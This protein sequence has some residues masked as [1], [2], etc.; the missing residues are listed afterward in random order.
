MTSAAFHKTLRAT[1]YLQPDGSPAVGLIREVSEGPPRL[2]PAIDDQRIGLMA[3]AVFTVRGAVVS[4]FKDAGS[5]RP[6][7]EEEASWHEAAWNLGLAPLLWVVTPTEVRL[8]DCYSPAVD[9]DGRPE[10]KPIGV[11]GLDAETNLQ[12]LDRACGRLSTETGAFWS[13]PIGSRINRR[14]RVDRQ[15]LAEIKALEEELS[16]LEPAQPRHED[17]TEQ[18]PSQ[19]RDFAQRLIGRTIFTWF[20]LDRGELAQPILTR[21]GAKSLADMLT[22]RERAFALFDWLRE[23]FNGDLFPMDDPEAERDRLTEDHLEPLR[24]FADSVSLVPGARGQGRLFRFRFDA[25]PVDL[26]S[27]IYQ[28]FARSSAAQS[29]RDQSLHYTPF[30]LIHL[31]LD[32]VFEGLEADARVI[33]PTCGSGAFLVEAFRRLVWMKTKGRPASRSIVREVLYNQLFGMDINLAALRIAAFGLYLTALELDEDPVASPSDLRFEALIGRTLFE[34]DALDRIPD[35]VTS[36]TFGAVVGNPPWQYVSRHRKGPK[37]MQGG[38]DDHRPRRSPDQSFLLAAGRLAGA[39]GRI[40][41]V[42]KAT[43]FFS[44]D[45]FALE[46]RTAILEAFQPAAI[47]NLSQLRHEGL[48]PDASGPALLFFARCKLMDARAN[49]MVGSV[50]WSASF[51]RNG[52]FE[53]GPADIRTIALSRVVRTPA[54]LKAATFGTARDI[55]L[56]ERLQRTFPA[57]GDWLDQ[58]GINPLE[59][60]G[61]GLQK[62]GRPKPPPDSFYELTVLSPADYRALRINVGDLP[63]FDEPTLHFARSRSIYRSPLLIAPKACNLA[64]LEPGRFSAAISMEDVLYTSSFYGISFRDADLGWAHTLSG[65]LNSSLTTH[66]FA[67][68]GA[69][70]G[71]ERT[72]IEAGELLALRVPR[73]DRVEPELLA[74]VIT[75]ERA[76]ADA[77]AKEHAECLRGLD[78][79]VF[80][81]YGLDQ[82]E[83]TIARDA[84]VRAR[85]MV[86]DSRQERARSAQ[87]PSTDMLSDYAR[88]AAGA[89]N[90]YLQAKGE[91]HVVA[92]VLVFDA[93]ASG[94][95]DSLAAVR[96]RMRAGAPGDLAPV[97]VVPATRDGGLGG[98]LGNLTKGATLPYL[99]ERRQLRI[100]GS[101]DITFIK[102][103]E[104][105]Y[106]SRTAGLNDADVILADH[107]IVSSDVHARG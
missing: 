67:F 37:R 71:L 32:P 33:D 24:L 46:A 74:A 107:W 84:V 86:F 90:A 36:L 29:A 42:M 99:N 3:D 72:T 6:A 21:T 15:L 80:D 82:D 68:A 97:H 94:L 48:F 28:Q 104:R 83:R 58:V 9:P 45:R 79:A 59:H 103:R 91:R 19:A 93:A 95:E 44:R 18:E 92:D 38:S 65:I 8:Y 35:A 39:D 1:G 87:P 81:L 62:V 11:F 16:A 69:T 100:Y 17:E 22:S 27:S 102:P 52:V 75:A 40:G 76:L 13:G 2:R 89:I 55:W 61:Q 50:P 54:I 43:P 96:F 20:L 7:P 23:T 4:L 41:V 12:E 73:L 66:Q 5:D 10:R 105:R 70:W 57:L 34:A 51:S 98:L 49:L 14:F 63:D 25:I 106:W 64:A 31:T 88:E 101:D 78:E 30:E 85:P 53:V 77:D 26:V 47:I 56:T 60:R